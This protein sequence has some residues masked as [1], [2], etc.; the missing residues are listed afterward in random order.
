MGVGGSAVFPSV[1]GKRVVLVGDCWILTAS[2]TAT[3]LSARLVGAQVADQ[4]LK[5]CEPA[6]VRQSVPTFQACN[7]CRQPVV[8][9]V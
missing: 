6:G 7:E 9:N 8:R 5:G 2:L 4:Q 3:S 1:L